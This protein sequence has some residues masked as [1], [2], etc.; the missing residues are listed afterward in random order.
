[1]VQPTPS[2]PGPILNK[3]VVAKKTEKGTPDLQNIPK[4]IQLQ[5]LKFFG[6]NELGISGPL[7]S[8]MWTV[9]AADPKRWMQLAN[10]L[11]I[12]ITNPAKAREEVI[13]YFD[14]L[15][16]VNEKLLFIS[17]IPP[18]IRNM[19]DP[20]DA[21]RAIRKY[22]CDNIATVRSELDPIIGIAR[23]EVHL[24]ALGQSKDQVFLTFLQMLCEDGIDVVSKDNIRNWSGSA[25]P[26]IYKVGH[27]KTYEK[28]LSLMYPGV[29]SKE[30]CIGELQK[31]LSRGA[32]VEFAKLII[33]KGKIHSDTLLFV[34]QL[35]MSQGGKLDKPTVELFV[36][37]AKKTENLSQLLGI[38]KK[39]IL[40]QNSGKDVLAFTKEL[41]KGIQEIQSLVQAAIKGKPQ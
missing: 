31:I 34:W 13:Q 8:K 29:M 4:V 5:I 37:N 38:H 25:Q 23:S 41:D 11:K 6:I 18:E 21:N 24:V 26:A 2:D 1:M 40:S 33:E 39:L 15:K 28:Y 19:Q 7:I 22:I 27:L 35:H 16:Q 17:K 20:V 30:Q 9:L 12:N 3:E 14:L 32:P 36:E 10:N